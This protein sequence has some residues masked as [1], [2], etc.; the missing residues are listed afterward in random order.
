MTWHLRL[1]ITIGVL[2]VIG[3]CGVFGCALVEPVCHAIDTNDG[4]F[5]AVMLGIGAL[6]LFCWRMIGRAQGILQR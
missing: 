3:I 2:L 5:I 6:C 1:V 4:C